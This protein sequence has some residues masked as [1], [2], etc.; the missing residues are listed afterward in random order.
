MFAL[1]VWLYVS[2]TRARDRI[3]RY[4]FLAYIT[5]LIVSI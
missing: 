1:G 4:A 3:G 2:A 5:L